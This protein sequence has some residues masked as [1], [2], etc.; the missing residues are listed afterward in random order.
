VTRR[1]VIDL[2]SP[3]TAWRAPRSVAAEI[4]AALGA[5]WQVHEVDQPASSDGDGGIGSEESVRAA[6]GS[7][8]YL[9]YGVPPGV[10]T[11]ARS[12]LRWVHTGSA[13]VGAS[14]PHLRGT[15]I[16]LTNSAGVHA[17]P[18]ADWVL[19]AIAY[20]TRSLDY[21]LEAQRVERWLKAEFANFQYPVSELSDLR[22]G[23]YGLGGIG[24][25]VARRLLA[26]GSR[27]AG[28]R[29]HPERGAPADAP[30]LEW[31]GGSDDL[32]RLAA[33]SDCLV[34]A[35]PHTRRTAG[36]VDRAILQRLPRGAVVVNV[37]RGSLLDELALLELLDSGHLRGAALDVFRVEPP[38]QG[39][40]FWRHSR[41]LM[42]PHAGAVTTRFWER[43]LALILENI[44]RYLAGAPLKNVVDFEAQY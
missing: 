13:G 10:V 19:A 20:F 26:L 31:V 25:A 23:I 34:I 37:S 42:S 18:M 36:M 38:V 30:G 33:R 5:G 12:T 8:I 27:V 28:L 40:P 16:V 2:A 39:H 44:R 17:E 22:V 9:G 24:T 1:L 35:A 7:E 11:A 3:H 43:E 4:A 29:R 6:S 14:L 32:A 15:G 41:V 21:M